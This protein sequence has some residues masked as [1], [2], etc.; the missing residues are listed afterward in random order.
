MWCHF[1][2]KYCPSAS[3]CWISVCALKQELLSKAFLQVC[4]DST[5][6]RTSFPR[7][8]PLY[9]SNSWREW[10]CLSTRMWLH[11]ESWR[12]QHQQD[13]IPFWS[14]LSQP[15]DPHASNIPSW[16]ALLLKCVCFDKAWRS[17]QKQI[18]TLIS[19][20]SQGR[21]QLTQTVASHSVYAP[22]TLCST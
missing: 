11:L 13:K 7:C 19:P 4:N 16:A 10:A 22:N 21:N 18:Y 15:F 1:L 17:D 6:E 9:C 8:K 14:K 12:R 5:I 3:S 20:K 2:M